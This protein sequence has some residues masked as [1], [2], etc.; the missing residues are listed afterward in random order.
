VKTKQVNIGTEAKPKIAKIGDYWEGPI[1]DQVAKLLHEYHDLF[2]T[3]F[4]DLKG[5]IKD[6]WV[7]KITLELDV[8]PVKK[9]SYCLNLKY[10]EKVC[11]ELD[12]ML[13]VGIIEPLEESDSVSLMV[14]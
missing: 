5:I 4:T 11:I 6:L 9:R 10:M 2:P 12:M 7:M 13:M 14:V 3:K 1:V 8:K